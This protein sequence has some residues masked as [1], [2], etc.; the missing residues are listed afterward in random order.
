M[1]ASSADVGLKQI[2]QIDYFIHIGDLL[3]V[4]MTSDPVVRLT[5]TPGSVDD[6][7]GYSAA[8][9]GAAGSQMAISGAWADHDNGIDS[10]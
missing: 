1:P 9:T 4:A 3:S 10:G 7:F 8:I 2:A 5:P 6:R